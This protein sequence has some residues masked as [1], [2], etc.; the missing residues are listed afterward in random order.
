MSLIALQVGAAV[1]QSVPVPTPRPDPDALE[2]VP[3]PTPRP[4]HVPPASSEAGYASDP[5]FTLSGTPMSLADAIFLGLRQNRSIKSAYINRVAQKFSLKVAEDRFTPQFAIAGSAAR[6]RIGDV[7]STT[8][9]VSPGVSVLAPTGAVFDFAWNNSAFL[10]ESERT[11]SSIAELSVEQPLLRGAGVRVNTAPVRT[12]RLGERINRLQLSATVSETVASVI[13]SHRDLLLAQEELALAKAAVGRAEELVGINAALISAGRMAAVESVQAEADL[14]SQKLRLLQAAQGLDNARFALLDLLGLDLNSK[15]VARENPTP[16]RISP[17]ADKLMSVALMNRPDYLGQLYAIEQSR[18]GYEVAENEQLWDIDLFARGR[19]GREYADV[20]P[21]RRVA[22][23]TAGLRFDI[24][25]NDLS[26][27]QQ[28]VNAGTDLRSAE[29]QLA[30][31]RS[32]IEMQI[33][34]TV[35]EIEI[36]WQQLGI[37]RRSHELALEAVDIERTKLSAGRSSTFEVR[38]LENDLRASE[39]RLLQARV[40][41]LN[42]LTRLDLQLGTTLKTWEIDLR[43]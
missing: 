27:R 4:A 9:D 25:F 41:Y 28:L 3:T 2:A 18:L 26:R 39:I 40:G 22:D 17:Q 15:I 20:A 33:L 31:I 14:E 35:S 29:L 34:S 12:A 21:T 24:P 7:D 19:L 1:A 38:S 10:G 30:V 13:F 6:H 32:G 42:A 11:L 37:A 23:I 36:L 8:I 16:K 5:R 43:D